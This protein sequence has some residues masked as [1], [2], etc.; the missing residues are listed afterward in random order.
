VATAAQ[1]IMTDKAGDT[2]QTPARVAVV[3]NSSMTGKTGTLP[4]IRVDC[5]GVT[6]LQSKCLL[7]SL[8]TN[9]ASW[10]FIDGISHI[11]IVRANK[12]AA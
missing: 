2:A 11:E 1:E 7:A 5:S 10:L 6:I 8:G 4:A 9:T 3:R 12:S